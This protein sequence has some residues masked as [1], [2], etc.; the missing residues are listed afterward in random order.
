VK[1]SSLLALV[2]VGLT[3][4]CVVGVCVGLVGIGPGALLG[5]DVGPTPAGGPPVQDDPGRIAELFPALGPVAVAHWQIRDARPRTC[6]DVAPMTY[7][8]DGVVTLAA[9]P[10][11]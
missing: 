2:L 7:G 10:A 1:R 6:P 5:C 3:V 9:D 4:L 11:G 8:Y